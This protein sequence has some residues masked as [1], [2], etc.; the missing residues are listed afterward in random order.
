MKIYESAVRKPIST[1]LLF[2][3]VI[4]FGLFSLKNLAIDQY[5]EMDP[6]YITVAT[7]YA[8]AN[9]AD[10]ETMNI[11]SERATVVQR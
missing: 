3:G 11:T 7:V 8:G 4:I 2:L 9:A 5:P 10:I 1:C 6:P